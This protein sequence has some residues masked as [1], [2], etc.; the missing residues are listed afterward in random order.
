MCRVG[1]GDTHPGT[2][3]LDGRAFELVT[4][5]RLIEVGVHGQGADS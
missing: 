1:A 2:T 3:A 5:D 4:R